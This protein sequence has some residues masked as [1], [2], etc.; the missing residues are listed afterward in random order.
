[1]QEQA[2]VV[3]QACRRAGAKGITADQKS[4]HASFFFDFDVEGVQNLHVLIG[5]VLLWY[6]DV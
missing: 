4:E 1:M 3:R 2:R 5:F 6:F